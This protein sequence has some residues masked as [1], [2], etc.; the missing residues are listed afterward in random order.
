MIESITIEASED[1]K[2]ATK[3]QEKLT[4]NNTTSKERRQKKQ[5]KHAFQYCVSKL[6]LVFF[7][8]I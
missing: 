2:E 7:Y 1:S 6:T 3:N 5:I 4:K 8:R